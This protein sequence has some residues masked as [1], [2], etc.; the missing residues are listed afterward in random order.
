[1]GYRGRIVILSQGLFLEKKTEEKMLRAY[2]THM[3]KQKYVRFTLMIVVLVIIGLIMVWGRAFYGSMEAYNQGEIYLK[4]NK[5]IKAITFFDRSIH[6]YTPFSPYIY[7]SAERLWEICIK[8]EQK[9]D[10]RLALIATRTIRRGFYAARSF[11]TPGKNWINKC[12][13][14][15]NELVRLELQ[16]EEI[17][18][19]HAQQDKPIHASQKASPPS[20]LWS[21]IVEIGF[22][23]WIGSAISFIMFACK[24]DRKVRL[25]APQA[26]AWAG[27]GILFFALWIV[28]MMKA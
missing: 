5:Y 26:V 27:I 19:A 16:Q 4:E 2:Q 14:K 6:W 13:L 7:R 21:I 1:M 23:G 11:Y 28:G 25:L 24:G 12:D 17:Q 18:D 3:S 22:L 15:I 8:A 9:G 20:T 10:I